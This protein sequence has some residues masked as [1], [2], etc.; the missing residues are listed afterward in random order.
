MTGFYCINK[1]TGTNST[2][3]VSI[4]KKVTKQKCGH[5]GTLDP[6]AGGVLPVAV[7]KATKLFDYFLNKDKKYYAIGLFG[8]ETDTLDSEGIITKKESVEIKKTQIEQILPQFIGK[9]EQIPPKYSAISINGKR[10]Y[11]LARDGKEVEIPP[12]KVDIYDIKCNKKTDNLFE[13]YIH[14]SSGTYVRALI[15]DIA[16]KLGTI[17][18]TLCIIRMS[19]GPFN[20]DCSN[21]LDEFQNGQAKFIEVDQVVGLSKN[22]IDDISTKKLLNG[23]IVNCN[24]SDGECI[25]YNSDSLIGICQTTNGKTKIKINLWEEQL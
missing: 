1:Q 19:S 15:N 17:A 6:L 12:R 3:V 21:T 24:L 8:I 2:K 18:T 10:S 16:K 7:G 14:C 4:I 13:F 23:Q 25:C 22:V 11:E 20:I 9:I 5:L